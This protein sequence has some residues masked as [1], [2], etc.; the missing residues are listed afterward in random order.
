MMFLVND[1]TENDTHLEYA[2]GSHKHRNPWKRFS[3]SDE[4]IARQYPIKS[5]VGPKG[6]LVILDVGS[7]FHRGAHRKGSVRKTLQCVITAGHYFPSREQKMMVSDWP[8]FAAY[9][10][11]VRRMLDDLRLD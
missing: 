5:C 2:V 3:Y 4:A 1:L 7:G 11:H 8:A 10:D 6:T 9:P